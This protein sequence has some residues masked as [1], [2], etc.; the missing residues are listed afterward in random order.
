MLR[1]VSLIGKC[2]ACSCFIALCD[3]DKGGH[4]VNR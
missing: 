2:Y 1:N 3:M 4:N